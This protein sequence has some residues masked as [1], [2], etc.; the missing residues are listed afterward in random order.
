MNKQALR[1]W[2]KEER[3]K[4]DIVKI[5]S[6]LVQKLKDTKEYRQSKNIMIF[7]PKENEINLL[8]LLKDKSKKFYLPKIDGDNLLC[9]PYKLGDALSDSSFKTKE[10][11]TESVENTLLNL[12]IVPALAVDKNGYR[13]GYGGG[14]YDRFLLG[15]NCVKIVCI[16]ENFIVKTVY[17][18]RHDIKIDKIIT[19]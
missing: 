7:Y 17:P 6:E 11:K 2:A 10:P 4:L 18:E 12:V 15:L 19:D 14:Y 1:K 16:P 5:S 3:E 8:E 13:L 9:C